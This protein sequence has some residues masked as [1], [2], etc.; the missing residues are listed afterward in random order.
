MQRRDVFI[1]FMGVSQRAGWIVKTTRRYDVR[2]GT[3]LSVTARMT[4]ATPGVFGVTLATAAPAFAIVMR[5]IGAG[6]PP[7]GAEGIPAVGAALDPRPAA[8]A[9]PAPP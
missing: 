3:P 5:G 2:A 7:R 4:C 9:P 1:D 8:A 6:R